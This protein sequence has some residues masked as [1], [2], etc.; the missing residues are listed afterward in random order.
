MKGVQQFGRWG[1]LTPR[2]IGPFRIVE[3]V[4]AIS[5]RLDLPTSILGV[6]DIFFVSML[7]KHLRDKEQQRVIDASELE[8]QANLATI[9]IPV[10]I[11]VREDK[12]L[13]NKVIHLVKVQWNRKGAEEASWE[14]EEDMHRDHPHLFEQVK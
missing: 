8:I 3:R 11:L 1:K 14:H 6:H 2:Y 13:R 7:K 4:G 12:K 10:C 9:E 5:Y